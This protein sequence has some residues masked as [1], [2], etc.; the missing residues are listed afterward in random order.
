M[1]GAQ[2]PVLDNLMCMTASVSF[3]HVI[4]RSFAVQYWCFP[5]WHPAAAGKCWPY[6]HQSHPRWDVPVRAVVRDLLHNP[7]L[8]LSS[9]ISGRL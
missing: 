9:R 4:S 3:Q 7:S 5:S 1:I 2:P 8:W 6:L